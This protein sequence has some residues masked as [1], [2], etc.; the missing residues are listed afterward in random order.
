[1]ALRKL[2]GVVAKMLSALDAAKIQLLIKNTP[3][4]PRH[5]QKVADRQIAKAHYD[6]GIGH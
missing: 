4:M 3:I 2:P 6:F 1:M 5:G